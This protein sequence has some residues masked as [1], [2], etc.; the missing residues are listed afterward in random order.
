MEFYFKDL[1][2][3]NPLVLIIGVSLVLLLTIAIIK[4]FT[5]TI[6]F[7]IISLTIYAFYLVNNN[8]KIPLTQKEL[9]KQTTDQLK[10]IK[11]I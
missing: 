10:K 8:Q 3:S 9:I 2:N 6:V 5:K 11:G 7:L 4:T 1:I